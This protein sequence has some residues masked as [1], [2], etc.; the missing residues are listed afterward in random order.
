MARS[1]GGA[2]LDCSAWW[3]AAASALLPNTSALSFRLCTGRSAVPFVV[4]PQGSWPMLDEVC[5]IAWED[6]SSDASSAISD[7]S[8]FNFFP[9]R[10]SLLRLLEPEADSICRCLRRRTYTATVASSS[11]RIPTQTDPA[12]TAT[13]G[14]ARCSDS[15][16]I[17]TLT[18][19]R[20]G[21]QL[22]MSIARVDSPSLN[23]AA[24]ASFAAKRA[25]SMVASVLLSTSTTGRP[26]T[27][28]PLPANALTASTVAL[29]H[30]AARASLSSASPSSNL[31]SGPNTR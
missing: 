28:S 27:K 30:R 21:M 20:P 15:P 24:S 16:S 25:I 22:K 23:L 5:S 10:E 11:A 3:S 31:A 12:M 19:T 18:S 29:R 7:E 8:C 13:A 14:L 9:P 4:T 2:P 17:V 6:R 26:S 1:I